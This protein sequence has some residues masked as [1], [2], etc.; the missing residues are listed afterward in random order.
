MPVP[1]NILCFTLPSLGKRAVFLVAGALSPALRVRSPSANRLQ[2]FAQK[3]PSRPT[4]VA[5]RNPNWQ[6]TP[7][8]Q[9]NLLRFVPLRHQDVRTRPLIGMR[10][11]PPELLQSIEKVPRVDIVQTVSDKQQRSPERIAPKPQIQRRL[12]LHA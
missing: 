7:A 4:R 5:V 6:N 12:K 8:A 9:H 3:P 1:R 10:R 11:I 2:Q